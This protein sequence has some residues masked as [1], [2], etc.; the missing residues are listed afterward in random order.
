M[1]RRVIFIVLDS[2]GCGALPD[3]ARFGD[4]ESNTLGHIAETVGLSVPNLAALG[5]GKIVPLATVP[6]T[7]T[8]HACFGRA[9][10]ISAGKDTTTGH[11]EL[12]GVVKTTDWPYYPKG[13]PQ[14]LLDRFTEAAGVPGVLC[15]LPYSGTVV[16]NEY[17]DEHVA[18]RKPIVYT[19]G[20]SVFQI[21]CH[22]EI[23]PPEQLYAQC[24]AARALLKGEHEVARV[25][26]RPFIGKGNGNYTRTKNRRDFSIPPQGLT[27]HDVIVAADMAS[28]AI[29]KI[30]DIYEHRGFTEEIHSKSNAE[31]MER[32]LAAMQSL[33]TDGMIMTNL[34]DFDM[35]YGHRRDAAGYRD[36]LQDF[37]AFLPQLIAALREGD[38]MILTADHGNDPTHTGT[39]H[40][41]EYVPIL[42][43]VPG[44]RSGVDLGVRKSFAD[45]AQTVLEH[46]GL[47]RVKHGKSFLPLMSV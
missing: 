46:L 23:Y 37:D 36:A 39:D 25:I 10:E 3:A 28:I 33:D 22:E 12:A 40:T 44:L 38:L 19:S 13:F 43:M 32:T 30:G 45:M 24:R 41:R 14:D 21:A 6:P 42:A 26:A 5:L 4:A 15:N 8:P 17:G 9:A 31:G 29:G 11:W 47:D 1:N 27:M 34:V 35:L 16:I 18:T 2:V 7:D 20:D